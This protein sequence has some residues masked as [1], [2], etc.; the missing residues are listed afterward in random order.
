MIAH[1]FG[2]RSVASAAGSYACA[3]GCQV[4][5][6]PPNGMFGQ[7]RQTGH[8]SGWQRRPRRLAPPEK[9]PSFW[10]ASVLVSLLSGER[11]RHREQVRRVEPRA[12]TPCRPRQKPGRAGRTPISSIKRER[13]LRDD[14]EPAPDPIA[15][16]R[17]A[18]RPRAVL[19]GVLQVTGTRRLH[20]RRA[21]EHQPRAARPW[22]RR[23]EQHRAK[24]IVDRVGAELRPVGPSRNRAPLNRAEGDVTSPAL[25]R[26]PAR[27][28]GSARSCRTRSP[29]QGWRRMTPARTC[30]LARPRRRAW[31]QQQV[32]R[33]WRT[34]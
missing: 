11:R 7:S 18:G 26:R 22:P 8:D 3:T 20:G 19:Q 32:L 9:S 27:A 33:C 6:L 4:D 1:R 10:S 2:P 23:V 30:H 15:T 34:R 21:A 13:H 17:S 5:Q 14:H 29:H 12:T 16:P 28:A 31:R 25:P 24:S